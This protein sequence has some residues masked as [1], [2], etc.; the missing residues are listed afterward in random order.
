MA[1]R[2]PGGAA[3]YRAGIEAESAM[4]ELG[5]RMVGFDRW[6]VRRYRLGLFLHRA[7][8]AFILLGVAASVYRL[9]CVAPVW[10][11]F[12]NV[13][14]SAVCLVAS[15]ALGRIME[16]ALKAETAWFLEYC[17]RSDRVQQ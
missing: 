7:G 14:A 2:D 15:A 16:R 1:N 3:V 10:L 8:V 9:F 17:K 4:T 13:A 6:W 11:V 12:G 5:R